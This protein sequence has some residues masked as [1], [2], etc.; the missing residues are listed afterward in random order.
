MFFVVKND[1]F[2]GDSISSTVRAALNIYDHHLGTIFYPTEHDPG[3]PT[4]Y[5]WLLAACWTIFGK[6]LFVAHLFSVLWST[7]LALLFIK[8]AS[9]FLK[10][11]FLVYASLL[12][13]VFPTWLSQSAMMLNTTAFMF[14]ALLA[15]YGF[16]TGIKKWQYSG[17]MVMMLL[18]TQST[19]FL[20]GFA[21]AHFTVH[22]VRKKENIKGWLI[23][24]VWLF[25]LPFLI[26][27]AWVFA[28]FHHTGWAFQSPNYT[29]TDNL[30]NTTSFF[31]SI[32]I[33][34][35]RLI[36]FGMLPVYTILI[37]A[38]IKRRAIS[39]DLFWYFTMVL[40][41]NIVVMALFL[42]NTI[43][44]RYFLVFQ[45]LSFLLVLYV[46]QSLPLIWQRISLVVIFL[47][48][49]AGNYMYYPG[50]TLGDASLA[51]RNYFELE[52][53]MRGQFEDTLACYSYAPLANE[54]ELTRLSSEG[55]IIN[56][57]RT[58]DLGEYPVIL[59]SNLNAEFTAKQKAQLQQWPGTSFEKGAVYVTLFFNP[60]FYQARPEWHKREPGSF[61]LW[62]TGWKQKLKE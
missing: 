12:V 33:I 29:D 32:L 30:N 18:H 36:D 2:F 59:Q 38:V 15:F 48:L 3:H 45:F 34:L 52:K 31:R 28:H 42:E 53:Q 58:E 16:V 23:T 7:A 57:I 5:A 27:T 17:M 41:V 13:C 1:P 10:P 21:I 54:P 51:Y 49:V 46:I 9:L 6:S 35:W 62:F 60:A 43:G 11:P 24:N 61:E 8:L 20:L 37:L 14:F 22:V 19:F 47:S 26:Y 25:T 55:F 39:H 50:K 56:R 40:L 4:L 44:H